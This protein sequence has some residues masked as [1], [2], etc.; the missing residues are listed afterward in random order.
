MHSVGLEHQRC[1]LHSSNTF[2]SSWGTKTAT[3]CLKAHFLFTV[4]LWGIAW[5]P[6]AWLVIHTLATIWCFLCLLNLQLYKSPHHP[7]RVLQNRKNGHC[8]LSLTFLPAG[9]WYNFPS[10][11]QCLSLEP[12]MA[13]ANS[14]P[15]CDNGLSVK[16]LLRHSLLKQC[17][18]IST[19]ASSGGMH[20]SQKCWQQH[21]KVTLNLPTAG[22][23]WLCW[24]VVT[25]IRHFG[26]KVLLSDISLKESFFPV[27]LLN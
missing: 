4:C 24:L 8:H 13:A 16:L 15:L 7:S 14:N 17:P 19:L 23:Y 26:S 12:S 27:H 22:K 2:L 9:G 6:P 1:V 20:H 10:A 25:F 3:F 5:Q 11:F 18:Q 21:L